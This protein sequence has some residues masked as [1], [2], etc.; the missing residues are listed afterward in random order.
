MTNKIDKYKSYGLTE[1]KH[2]DLTPEELKGV[3]DCLA[4]CPS[5][6]FAKVMYV[7]YD[8]YLIL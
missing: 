7:P 1:V 3:R 8:R 4:L 5:P 6:A 2:K